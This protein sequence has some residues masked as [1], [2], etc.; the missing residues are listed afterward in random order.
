MPHFLNLGAGADMFRLRDSVCALL[1]DNCGM[2]SMFR[3]GLGGVS[4]HLPATGGNVRPVL[5]SQ[6]PLGGLCV[7]P[8][9]QDKFWQQLLFQV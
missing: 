4:V 1:K 6:K 5:I 8:A 9:W 2:F 7:R 3:L